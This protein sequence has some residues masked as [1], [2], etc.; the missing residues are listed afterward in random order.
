MKHAIFLEFPTKCVTK[1]KSFLDSRKLIF[2]ESLVLTEN[3]NIYSTKIRGTK[4]TKTDLFFLLIF[5]LKIV[6]LLP[7]IWIL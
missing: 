5:F 6:V 4:K 7:H 3:K 1:N 2:S